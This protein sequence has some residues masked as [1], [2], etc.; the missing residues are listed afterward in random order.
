LG[1]V[2]EKETGSI[3]NIYSSTVSRLEFLVGKL[4]PYVAISAVNVVVLWLMAVLLFAVPFK[5][6]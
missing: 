6:S 2:R 5:G 4:A 3:Y 1:V